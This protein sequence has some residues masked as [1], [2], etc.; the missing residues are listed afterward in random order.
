MIESRTS[1]SPTKEPVLSGE[2]LIVTQCNEKRLSKLD[3]H[4]GFVSIFIVIPKSA[5]IGNERPEL[6]FEGFSF[7]SF[8]LLQQP[9]GKA[10]NSIIC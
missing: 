1:N 4:L 7:L 5:R 2:Y 8:F 6:F 10:L 3:N 9:Q